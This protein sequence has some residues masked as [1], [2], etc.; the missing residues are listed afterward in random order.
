MQAVN[1][2]ESAIPGKLYIG[3]VTFSDLPFNGNGELIVTVLSGA[4]SRKVI[5]AT[6][7]SGNTSPY[8]WQYT[9][10]NNGSDHYS[11]WKS[12][13]PTDSVVNSIINDATKIP[14]SG[15]VY[16]ELEGKQDVIDSNNKLS[17]DVVD[18]TNQTHLFVSAQEKET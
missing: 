5:F 15:A 1:A 11:G 3:D 10:W 4:V 8:Y 6:L 9:Y 17:S 2:S 16:T 14:T 18:D 13:V 7:T 12:F